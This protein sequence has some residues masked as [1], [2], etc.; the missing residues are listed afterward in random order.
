MKPPLSITDHRFGNAA[1]LRIEEFR[2]P[3][4]APVDQVAAETL[5]WFTALGDA[6]GAEVA[7]LKRRLW[8]IRTTAHLTLMSYANAALSFES[9]QRAIVGLARYYPQLAQRAQHFSGLLRVLV[10]SSENPKSASV[11][12]LLDGSLE[13][14]NRVGLVTMMAR[15]RVPGWPSEGIEEIRRRFP[16]VR[17]ITGTAVLESEFFDHVVIPGGG[18][19]CPI[20]ADLHRCGYAGKLSVVVYQGEYLRKVER[21]ALPGGTFTRSAP[22]SGTQPSTGHTVPVVP[23]VDD[24]LAAAPD[25]WVQQRFWQMARGDLR[26]SGT[27]E[28]DVYIPARLVILANAWRTFLADDQS[29]IEV[30][31]V[32]TTLGGGAESLRR[33]PRRKV[34]DLRAGHVIVLRTSRSGVD[35][36]VTMADS[37]MRAEN[38]SSLRSESLVWKKYL[39][40]AVRKHSTARINRMLSERKHAVANHRYIEV[41]TTPRVIRPESPELFEALLETVGSLDCL[42]KGVSGSA[43][44]ARFWEE[45]TELL[46]YHHV[47]G[48]RIRDSLLRRLRAMINAGEHVQDEFTITLDGADAGQLSLYRVTDV[49]TEVIEVPYTHLE[50][51]RTLEQ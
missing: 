7:Q 11:C 29:V 30:S 25:A 26:S 44:A 23:P 48:N 51:L 39:L 22:A 13:R 2:L 6:D 8:M 45:M 28:R 14:G 5:R 47:A 32:L 38:R 42:P 16:Q 46:H 49:D 43:L 27:G 4:F 20:H 18:K 10:E 12:A 21:N 17:L 37:L 35:Y 24:A 36:L 40:D 41:W 31:E 1:N 33:L 50:V 15:G 34:F 19:L 3:G 9:E